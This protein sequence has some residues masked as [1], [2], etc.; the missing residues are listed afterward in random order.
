M[1]I[2]FVAVR[3]SD[4]LLQPL[5]LISTNLR[6]VR[7]GSDIEEGV[8]SAALPDDSPTEFVELASDIDSMLE[9]L[10]TRNADAAERAAE[11]RR[12]LR[13]ILPPQ[14]A[15]RAEAGERNVVDQVAHATVAVVVISGLGALMEARSADE[16]RELLDQFVEEADA[17]ARQRGLERIRLTGDAYFA[18]CGTVRPYIDHAARSVAFA[19]DVRDLVRDLGDRRP[20]DLDDG[21]R[22]FRTGHR[23]A[24]RR[25]GS[26]L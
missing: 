16:A 15:Q 12:L 2:T 19:L 26:R 10:A 24:D 14:A 11:R 4:R 17:L 13:R 25:L 9:T 18:A 21:G 3:W 7:A 22:R 20:G 1:A 23:R 5:R 8:S 6:A